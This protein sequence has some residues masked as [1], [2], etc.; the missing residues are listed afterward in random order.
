MSG[1][2]GIDATV[3]ETYN[4]TLGNEA[5]LA[6]QEELMRHI[7]DDIMRLEQTVEHG[8]AGIGII[9]GLLS[10]DHVTVRDEVVEIRIPRAAAREGADFVKMLSELSVD[11]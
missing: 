8:V 6:R 7:H 3:D 9:L 5:K 11:D 1:P 10:P 2:I 4:K